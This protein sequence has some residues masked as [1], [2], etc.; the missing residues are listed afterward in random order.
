[1]NYIIENFVGFKLELGDSTYVENLAIAVKFGMLE[2]PSFLRQ[3]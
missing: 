3:N 1:M 2:V